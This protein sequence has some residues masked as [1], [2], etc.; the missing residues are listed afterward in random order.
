MVTSL[1]F[2]SLTKY[3]GNEKLLL[4]A[5]TWAIADLS[6]SGFK[7]KCK[8]TI[9]SQG[10]KEQRADGFSISRNLDFVRCTL[11]AGKPV[12][13]LKIQ[14]HSNN[15]TKYNEK[16]IFFGF[17]SASTFNKFKLEQGTLTTIKS[18]SFA[19]FVCEPVSRANLLRAEIG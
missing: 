1:V 6:H 3:K 16:N 14:P 10:V 11:V 19:R 4:V 8:Q 12:F 7:Y 9:K 5:D 17:R 18:S 15:Y 13:G 2:S